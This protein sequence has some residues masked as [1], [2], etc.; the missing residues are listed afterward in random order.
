[1]RTVPL[2]QKHFQIFSGVPLNMALGIAAFI[3]FMQPDKNSANK[4]GG[5]YREIHYPIQDD[6]A[7]LLAEKWL[8]G[9]IANCLQ[10]SRIFGADLSV[11]PGLEASV[12]EFLQVLEEDSPLEAIRS[13]L[14]KKTVA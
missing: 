12:N 5:K 14:A 10:D 1:M 3:R 9:E 11:F 7:G 4:H 2:L 8:G 13:I 6:K